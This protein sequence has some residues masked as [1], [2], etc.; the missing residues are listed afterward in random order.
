[1][2][3]D[4]DD[5]LAKREG[6]AAEADRLR[7]LGVPA[8]GRGRPVPRDRRRGRRAADDRHG[9]LR[10]SRRG[11]ASTR[12]RCRTRDFVTST[13]H[14]TLAGPR[15]GFVLC[16][17]STRRARPRELPGRAGRAADAHDR[18]QGGLLPDG[19]DRRVP[20]LPAPGAN[21]RRHAR[22]RPDRRRARRPHR[23]HRHAPPPA[24]PARDRL[25]RP[26]RPGPPRTSAP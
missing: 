23:R 21:E 20:R 5:V 7:R 10:R 19:V 15:A 4:Y 16:R 24:R 22:R 1:M 9:A 3:V 2:R 12:T 11:R 18:R 17:R 25:D 13:T 26:G 8:H 6:G 14:K